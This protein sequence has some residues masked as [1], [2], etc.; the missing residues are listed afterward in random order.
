MDSLR[1]LRS[2]VAVAEEKHFG[3]AAERLHIAQPPLSQQVRRLEAELG[4]EL[5][6]RT[7]RRVDLT[8]AGAAYLQRARAIL[9]AVDDAAH[10]ARRA[11]AGVVGHLTI[12]CVGSVTYSLLPALAR[13]LSED[14]PG[15][16]V[17]FRGEM[18][19]APQVEAL[20]EGA[21]DLALL[22]P[23]VTDGSLVATPLRRDRLVVAVPEDHPLAARRRLRVADL[24]GVD[25]IVHASD[26]RSAMYDVVRG[27][28]RDAGFEPTV[29]HEVGETS[30]LV[31]GGLGVAVVPEPVQ[32]LPLSGVVYVPLTRPTTRVDLLA[33]HRADR[34]EPH[35]RAALDIVRRLA[36]EPHGR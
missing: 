22:R 17:S 34:D 12:G 9:A 25:L 24:A 1:Q 7:T 35:L 2:F 30:T 18:L 33:A 36:A 8:P 20:R 23:P 27:L 13:R 21:I 19:A 4:V 11:A 3:R 16:D 15:V 14:L 31:A 29:R 26:R 28:C 6:V 5:L 10:E 32:A